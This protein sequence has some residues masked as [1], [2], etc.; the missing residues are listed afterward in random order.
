ME[1]DKEVQ[2]FERTY[3]VVLYKEKID[4]AGVKDFPEVR[5]KQDL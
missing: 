1:L 2:G 5:A 4:L 3:C